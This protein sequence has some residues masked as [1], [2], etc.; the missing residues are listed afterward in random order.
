MGF[1]RQESWSGL[2]CPP[3][4]NLP[5][6]EIEARCPVSPALASGFFTHECHLGRPH[7]IGISPQMKITQ[8]SINRRTVKL[9]GILIMETSGDKK[10]WARGPSSNVDGGES[11]YESERSQTALNTPCVLAL[12]WN[13]GKWKLIYSDREQGSGCLGRE[14]GVER[15][16]CRWAGGCPRWGCGPTYINRSGVVAQVC[17]VS[18]CNTSHTLNVWSLLKVNYTSVRQI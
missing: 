7:F 11:N 17:P 14:A 1:S 9:P 12:T 4:G 3:P 13:S 8:M 2:P 15:K 10:G 16:A 5:D 18:K 6:P